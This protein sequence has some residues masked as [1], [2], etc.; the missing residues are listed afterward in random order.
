MKNELLPIKEY[1]KLFKKVKAM[2]PAEREKWVKDNN[3]PDDDDFVG[4]DGNEADRIN[5][6]KNS[7]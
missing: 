6:K 4:F 7:L 1:M 5:K 2:S 3:V